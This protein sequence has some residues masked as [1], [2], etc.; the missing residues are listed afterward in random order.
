M[1]FVE[2]K[3]KYLLINEKE[4]KIFINNLN[5]INVERYEY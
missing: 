3:I 4:N 5:R 2:N 1:G